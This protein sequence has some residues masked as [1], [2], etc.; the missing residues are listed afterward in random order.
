MEGRLGLERE[1][2]AQIAVTSECDAHKNTSRRSIRDDMDPLRGGGTV[3]GGGDIVAPTSHAIVQGP[4]KQTNKNIP[5][6]SVD[7]RGGGGA[8]ADTDC[9]AIR[10]S[11]VES[12]ESQDSV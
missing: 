12:N 11:Q 4:T 2:L 3:G 7:P 6:L 5:R 10:A 8:G 1:R 9:P